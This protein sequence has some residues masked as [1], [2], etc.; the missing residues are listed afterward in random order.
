MKNKDLYKATFSQLHTSVQV[1]E[2]MKETTMKNHSN[3]S[4]RLFAVAAAAALICALG[5]TAMALNLFGL[6]DLAFPDRTTLHVPVPVFTQDPEGNEVI[7]HYD[8]EDRVVDM[9]SMQGYAD[10]PEAKA[11]VE[12]RQFYQEYT[13]THSFN[14]DIYDEGGK[15]QCYAV[16]DDAMAARLEEILAKYGLGLHREM[17]MLDGTGDLRGEV[18]ATFLGEGNTAFWGYIYDDGTLS[19]EGDAEQVDDKT[20]DCYTLEYQFRYVK[21]GIFDEVALN[22]GDL[23]DYTDWD[24]RT[25]GGVD[26]KLSLGLIRSFIWAET[27]EGFLFINVLSGT[28]GDDTF[29]SGPIGRAQLEALAEQFD[30]SLLS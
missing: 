23:A 12:W 28:Q 19:F 15:Y 20:L 11:C 10:T 27:K 8:Y 5:A 14:N 3:I 21:K 25:F 1:D 30:F 29:S 2:L 26:L 22:V 18:G 6:R 4:R 17:T 9:I 7:D 24:Y 16:Y 13:D